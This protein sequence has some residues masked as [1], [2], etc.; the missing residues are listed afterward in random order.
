MNRV[1]PEPAG[2]AAQGTPD[3]RAV[4][5]EGPKSSEKRDLILD[6]R[7]RGRRPDLTHQVTW[8][9]YIMV[10]GGRRPHLTTGDGAQKCWTAPDEAQLDNLANRVY[11]FPSYRGV[12]AISK[13]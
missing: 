7:C 8:P 1:F 12:A 11:P 5:M 9:Q 3:L 2:R 10:A 13:M 6:Q 4:G